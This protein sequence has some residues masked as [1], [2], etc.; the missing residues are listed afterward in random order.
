VGA[1]VMVGEAEPLPGFVAL[2]GMGGDPPIQAD[3]HH[4]GDA[5]RHKPTIQ[6]LVGEEE[7]VELTLN[8]EGFTAGGGA[9]FRDQHGEGLIHH[10][11]LAVGQVFI[12]L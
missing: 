9:D 8:V 4:I 5:E 2:S 12:A 10:L 7:L 1:V 6:S 11:L 3:S